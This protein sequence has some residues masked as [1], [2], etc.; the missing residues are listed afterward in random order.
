MIFV[1][2]IVVIAMR[3]QFLKT[4]YIESEEITAVRK[5][6]DGNYRA[7]WHEFYEIEYVVSGDGNCMIDDE[8]YALEHGMLF[9]MTPV[10]LHT[11]DAKKVDLYNLHFSST[12][13]NPSY[14]LSITS[15]NF[16]RAFKISPKDMP[17]VE[18]T[19]KELTENIEDKHFSSLLLNSLVAKLIK[20]A[21][22]TNTSRL[23]PVALAELYIINKFRDNISLSDV[24]KYAGFSPTYFSAIFK[25]ETGKSFK[26]YTDNLRYEY[27]KKLLLHS[28]F[29]VLQICSESGFDE[30]TNFLRRFKLRFGVSPQKFRN[31][32]K[33]LF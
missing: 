4:E 1:M 9:F 30:Y 22:K 25:K 15:S 31:I 10:N 19:L 7:H 29:T 21:D 32:H 3:E 17:F 12:V 6:I 13:C 11:V 24:A 2:I 5:N 26:E 28:D 20:S 8:R 33:S 27:A 18:T 23:S 16:P 14:L